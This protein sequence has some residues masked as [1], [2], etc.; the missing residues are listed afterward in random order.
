MGASI[1]R[2]VGDRYNSSVC[3]QGSGLCDVNLRIASQN[4]WSQ[5]SVD[6]VV[7]AI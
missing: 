6:A 7:G 2:D 3:S 5:L 1:E 4:Q